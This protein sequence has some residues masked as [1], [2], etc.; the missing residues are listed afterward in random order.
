MI[1]L[2]NEICDKL[3]NIAKNLKFVRHCIGCEGINLEIENPQHHPSIELTQ[4]CNL[5][6]IYCYSRL[7][8]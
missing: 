6:C 5:N 8:L 7:K 4:K 2:R 1:V 3:E